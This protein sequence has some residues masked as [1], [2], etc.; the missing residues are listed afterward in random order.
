MLLL[1]HTPYAMLNTLGLL[2]CLAHAIVL[3]CM[4]YCPYFTDEEIQV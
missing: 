2:S 3:W 4:Y 1:N